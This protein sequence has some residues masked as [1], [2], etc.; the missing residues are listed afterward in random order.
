MVEVVRGSVLVNRLKPL[1]SCSRLHRSVNMA[2]ASCKLQASLINQHGS[3]LLQAAAGIT[4][5]VN[6]KTSFFIQKHHP[7]LH[8][9]SKLRNIWGQ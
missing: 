7:I 3:S 4:A 8:W 1:A 6:P 9:K 2:Q 5:L